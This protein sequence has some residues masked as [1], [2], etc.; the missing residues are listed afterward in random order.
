MIA[1]A[2]LLAILASISFASGASA[3]HTG[4]DKAFTSKSPDRRLGW[5][6]LIKLLRTPVWLFGLLL[7]ALGAF[8]HIIAVYLA[9]ITVVQPIGILAVIWSVLIAAR[10][11]H[12]T[13]TRTMWLA[14]AGS[15]VGIVFFTILSTRHAAPSRSVSLHAMLVTTGVMW[16]VAAGFA[17]VGMFGPRWMRNL[18][19]SWGGAVLYGLG[20]GYMKIMTVVFRSGEVF[21]GSEFW[22]AALGLVLAYAVGGW[23]IQQ[24]YAS[25]PAEVVVGSMTTIDPLAAV[26]VGLVVLGEGARLTPAVGIGMGLA[27]ALAAG[28]VAVLSRFHPDTQRHLAEQ[29]TGG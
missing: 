25:G 28:G 11:N 29:A 2:V 4:V 24:G 17:A 12:T 22:A 9:P 5:S 8:I 20:T 19:W 13:P 16:A 18:A 1:L 14:V 26:M 23:L 7:V 21:T 15:V 10:L 6:H 3:Q 27:G